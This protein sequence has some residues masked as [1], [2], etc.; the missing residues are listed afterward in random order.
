MGCNSVSWAPYHAVASHS[1]EH[2]NA[3]VYR[4]ATG[5]C[6]SI[7]RVWRWVEGSADATWTEEPKVQENP[8]TG[9]LILI[10]ICNLIDK[11]YF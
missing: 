7:V 10:N 2:N 4:L 9:T 1:P 11:S 6:D 8:H 3:L 5:S